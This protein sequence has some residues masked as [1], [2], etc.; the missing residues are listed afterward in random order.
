MAGSGSGF[1]G[2][3][4]LESPT[5][6]G[7]GAVGSFGRKVSGSP[8]SSGPKGEEEGSSLSFDFCLLFISFYLSELNWSSCIF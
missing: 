6:A 2:S 3:S 5:K 7:K 1:A 8:Y 4:G